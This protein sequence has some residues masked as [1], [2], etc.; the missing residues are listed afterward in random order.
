MMIGSR[1]SFESRRAIKAS[2][3]PGTWRET[4]VIGHL[5]DMRILSSVFLDVLRFDDLVGSDETAD[6][7]KQTHNSI[8]GRR[9][10]RGTI[11][12]EKASDPFVAYQ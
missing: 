3:G 2:H 12:T 4:I 6:I 7:L 1:Q 11:Y 10:A 5:L 9:I 8:L